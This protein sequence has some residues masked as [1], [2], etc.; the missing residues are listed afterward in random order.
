MSL[1]LFHPLG[2]IEVNS[3]IGDAIGRGK[4]PHAIP[5]MVM[6]Y[7]ERHQKISQVAA[8]PK[9]LKLNILT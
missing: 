2:Y 5:N 9:A 7:L 1:E 8:V 3:A 4:K 6:L